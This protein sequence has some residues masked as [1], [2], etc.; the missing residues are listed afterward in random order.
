MKYYSDFI[1]GQKSLSSFGGIIYNDSDTFKKN[2]GRNPKH[3]TLSIPNKGQI[4]YGT[5]YEPYQFDI[6]CY[7]ERTVNEAEI[8]EWIINSGEQPFQYVG[9]DKAI[10][11]VY[12]G[13]L[14]FS[15][16]GND[17]NQQS[18]VTIPFIAYGDTLWYYTKSETYTIADSS[19]AS[20]VSFKT[21]ANK[22]SYPLISF[23]ANS[24]VVKFRWNNELN[25]TMKNL[26]VGKKY[27]I[28][29]SNDDIYYMLAG[30]KIFVVGSYESDIYY[31]MPIIKPKV[32][33]IL[34]V[35]EGH[36]L[37]VKIVANSKII[38]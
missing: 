33:N 26:T 11:A 8:T 18:I 22:T 38:E 37:D 3:I 16:Y 10:N 17:I 28:D 20:E 15:I 13:M 29:T 25:F 24:S 21:V 30:S 5:E 6:P 31:T 23:T 9:D 7:F 35:V 27:Y 1:F 36:A 4:Y 32:T 19:T 34:K 12:N 2:I 14:D